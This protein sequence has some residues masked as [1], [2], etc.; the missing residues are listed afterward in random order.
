[1]SSVRTR[2]RKP[3]L[4]WDQQTQLRIQREESI[5]QKQRE[6]QKELDQDM[7]QYFINRRQQW[8]E[9]D[10]KGQLFEEYYRAQ[11]TLLKRQHDNR[12]QR[13][14]DPNVY[15]S[16]EEQF[17]CH[18]CHSFEFTQIQRSE[19][20]PRIVW[21]CKKCRTYHVASRLHTPC[22]R[23]KKRAFTVDRHN[24]IVCYCGFFKLDYLG[25]NVMWHRL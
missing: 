10:R 20:D 15:M 24:Q 7:E 4:T 1:M 21:M 19:T 11:Q 22:E 18:Q 17:Y 13:Q 14:L 9:E 6:H 5:K 2:T 25:H 12:R 23:C 16:A 8:A 3:V